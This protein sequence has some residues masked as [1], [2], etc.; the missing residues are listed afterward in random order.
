[1]AQAQTFYHADYNIKK[2]KKK[3]T[4]MNISLAMIC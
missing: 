1:M 4:I 2:K 3:E